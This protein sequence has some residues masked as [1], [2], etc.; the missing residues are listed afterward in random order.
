[1]ASCKFDDIFNDPVLQQAPMDVYYYS[2]SLESK[3]YLTSIVSAS[4]PP[5]IS[6]S[7]GYLNQG[8]GKGTFLSIDSEKHLENRV[9]M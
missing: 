7:S 1:M 6:F 5:K 4:R 3:K 2:W 9:T 8:S